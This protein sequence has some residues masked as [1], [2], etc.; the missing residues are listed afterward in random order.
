ML[1]A[2]VLPLSSG[3]RW[4]RAF[5]SLFSEPIVAQ[6]KAIPGAHWEP[7]AKEWRL[8]VDAV[9]IIVDVLER[10]KVAKVVR[11]DENPTPPTSSPLALPPTL[12]PFQ[13]EGVEWLVRTALQDGGALLA[14]EMG[15]GKSAQ[16][17]VTADNLLPDGRV[18]VVCP[19]VVKTSWESQIKRWST[20]ST[21]SSAPPITEDTGPRKGKAERLR[22]AAALQRRW[23]VFSSDEFWRRPPG[24]A[25]VII[26]DEAHYFAD[27]RSKRSK[28]LHE[29]CREHPN[30]YRLAL[31]GTPIYARPV[32]LWHPLDLIC[33]GRFGRGWRAYE[34]R[35]CDGHYEEIRVGQGTKSVWVAA[36][37]TRLEELAERLTHVMLR[38][39]KA[40]VGHMLPKL[41]RDIVEIPL[42]AS[43]RAPGTYTETR[44]LTD[45]LSHSERFKI[46]PAIDLA[47]DIL[48]SGGHPLILT[49]RRETADTIAQA[50]LAPCVT[51]DTPHDQREAILREAPAAGVATLYSVT[52][53]ITLTNFDSVIMVGLDWIPSTM[54]QG[55]ARIHRLG[56]GRP[57]TIHYLVGLG[58][59]D[60]VIRERVIDRLDHFS[61]LTG[62]DSTGG[63]GASLRGGNDDDL[64]A[65][66]AREILGDTQ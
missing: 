26:L 39:T 19:S 58:T 32:D 16:A 59:V 13:R 53:G 46:D 57:V 20:L 55:E 64:L 66:L 4:L 28:G 51:G 6:L 31:T 61:S 2:E 5:R 42:G 40:E 22:T 54:L 30:A 50:L 7:I 15:L 29:W 8:P 35:Y 1:L 63:F 44:A 24:P 33:P 27:P 49:L 10:A 52:T 3:P 18:H 65:A 14:D 21:Y 34:A 43:A 38:R 9:P 11:R 48:A 25:G 41:T 60:E 45:A 12:Y 62:G 17:I 56:Q 23:S 37:A 47:R 36:G